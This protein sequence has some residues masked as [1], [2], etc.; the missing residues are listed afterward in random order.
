VFISHDDVT[1]HNRSISTSTH[2]HF[3]LT[4]AYICYISTY[5]YLGFNT[6]RHSCASTHIHI[7]LYSNTYTSV[8]QHM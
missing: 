3:S 1:L 6:C 4:N 7:H 8:S 2:I 5:T